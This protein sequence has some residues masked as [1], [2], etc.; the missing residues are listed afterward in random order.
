[1]AREHLVGNLRDQ[2]RENRENRIAAISSQMGTIGAD[3][4]PQQPMPSQDEPN[5]MGE[6]IRQW[7]ESHKAEARELDFDFLC[8]IINRVNGS[9]AVK[10]AC[11]PIARDGSWIPDTPCRNVSKVG[12]DEEGRLVLYASRDKKEMP[13]EKLFDKIQGVKERISGG[14]SF[15]MVKFSSEGDAI[16][17][18]DAYS[19]SLV[20]DHWAGLPFDVVFAYY[21]E[22]TRPEGIGTLSDEDEEGAE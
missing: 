19:H 21:N 13:V 20:N 6:R 10:V 14:S 18:T 4:K 12:V 17:L 2:I 11:N 9:S 8:K 1:M 15:V 22:D 3:E 5:P 16:R 7:G